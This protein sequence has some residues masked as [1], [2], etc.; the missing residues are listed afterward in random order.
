MNDI[1]LITVGMQTDPLIN[2]IR[3]Q[4][5]KRV[6][7]L[8][9]E[10]TRSKVEEVLEAVPIPRFDP[11]RDV[12]VLQQRRSRRQ[13]QSVINELDRLD[14]VYRIA[15]EQLQRLRHEEP[16]ARI[17]VDYTPGTKTMAAGLAMAAIDDRRVQLLLTTTDQRPSTGEVSGA[18]V[19]TPSPTATIHLLRLRQLQLPELL[20][21][22]DYA[23]ASALVHRV[24]TELSPEEA[25]AKGLLRLEHLLQAF[26]SWDRFDHRQALNEFEQLRHDA[27][28]CAWLRQLKRVVASRAL[29]DSLPLKEEWPQEAGH[30]LE[31]VEDLLRNAERRAAQHRYDDAVGRLYRALELTAQFLLKT[32]VNDKVGPEGLLTGNL[33]VAKLPAELQSRFADQEAPVQVGLEK[34]WDLLADLGHPAGELWREQ[35]SHL[36]NQLKVRNNSLFAHGFTPISYA[37]WR[38]MEAALTPFLRRVVST[39][40]GYSPEL[41]LSQL[42]HALVGLEPGEVLSSGTAMPA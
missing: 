11:D 12:V 32:S 17:G 2:C 25:A 26:D 1:L 4:R 40:P 42:P 31:A 41:D 9:S 6:V 29:L 35:K 37:D 14:C 5:P 22:F 36:L 34:A 20:E 15:W 8:C 28:S 7:F 21:R 18:T 13:D 10:K 3:S 38:K 19:P 24:R 27:C 16:G 39:L 30:G 23:A 33:D